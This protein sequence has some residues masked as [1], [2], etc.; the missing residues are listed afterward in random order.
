MPVSIAQHLDPV[1]QQFLLDTVGATSLGQPG[2][3]Q[4]LWSDYGALLRIPLHGCNF[5][6]V[7]V[8]RIAAPATDNHPRGW[9]ST[10]SHERKLRSYAVEASWYQDYAPRCDDRVRLPRCYGTTHVG[11]VQLIVLED[12][13]AA[14]Y[15][16]RATGL[17]DDGIRAC[18]DWLANLHAEFLGQPPDGLWP[19]GTY[20]HLETRPDEWDAMPEGDLKQAARWLD[21]QLKDCPFQTIVHGDAK[22]A[23]FC[24]PPDHSRVAAVDFQYVG[25]GVGIKDV[26]YFLGSCLDESGLMDKA[27]G[28][29]D[30]YFGCL[31]RVLRRTGREDPGQVEAHW[32]ELFPV[33]WADFNRFLHGWLPGHRKLHGFSVELER[34]ALDRWRKAGTPAQH[35]GDCP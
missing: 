11:Q 3:I 2:L 31:S 35:A 20:W 26:A 24:F 10:L 16:A 17:G 7:I 5:K 8:K 12:L 27:D 21:Q 23:N 29:L 9:N 15:P 13:D 14:G 6:S 32:R 22:L 18:L 25:G 33:A 30:D 34:Q 19:T 28:F 4:S 1:E